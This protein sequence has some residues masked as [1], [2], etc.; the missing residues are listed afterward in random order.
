MTKDKKT[1]KTEKHRTKSA[2]GSDAH[3]K[4]NSDGVAIVAEV[5]EAG[6]VTVGQHDISQYYPFSMTQLEF[7]EEFAKDL[8]YTRA[9]KAVGVKPQTVRDTWLPNEK[10]KA[11]IM[12]IYNVYRT[13]IKMTAENGA[14]RL[15]SFMNKV[16]KDYDNAEKVSDKAKLAGPM[17]KMVDSY[18]KASGHYNSDKDNTESQ[19]VINIDLGGDPENEKRVT[20]SG[21]KKDKNG[22]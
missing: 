17:S 11:E 22:E 16:E 13:N 19:V 10:F 9:A 12:E 20:I 5:Y 4:R 15:I 1:V 21:E 8:D 7:L 6:D 2:K 14:Y 18:L 3:A